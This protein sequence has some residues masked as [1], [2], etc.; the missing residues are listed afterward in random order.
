MV[1]MIKGPSI[2]ESFR[3]GF[4]PNLAW[5]QKWCVFPNWSRR[6]SK[7]SS[8][9]RLICVAVFPPICI[10]TDG[11]QLNNYTSPN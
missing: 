8:R 4:L 9:M 7:E 6:F 2:Y 10:R 5:Q 1:S 3:S 11:K